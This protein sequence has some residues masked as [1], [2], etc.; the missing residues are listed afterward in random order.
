MKITVKD[1]LSK[2][3]MAVISIKAGSPLMDA[4]KLMR[5]HK[6]GAVLVLGDKESIEGI[7]T[8]RD[9]LNAVD[10]YN[11]NI[12]KVKVDDMMTR[13]III[14]IPDDDIQYLMGIM[15][16]NRIR[17]IPIVNK[18]KIEGLVS[19]R[20]LIQLKLENVEFQNRLLSDY[21]ESG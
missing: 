19:V 21:I 14:A 4:V 9:I 16:K 12:E 13:N 11:G 20:D 10:K 5:V 18:N 17:H 1:I 8:E 3:G 2:K 15:A 7:L 6:I